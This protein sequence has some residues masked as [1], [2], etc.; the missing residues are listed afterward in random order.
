MEASWQTKVQEARAEVDGRMEPKLRGI[1]RRIERSHGRVQKGACVPDDERRYT[2]DEVAQVLSRAVQPVASSALPARRP[3][4]GITLDELEAVAAEAGIDPARV[5][6][7]ALSLGERSESSGR[8]LFFGP[9]PSHV[10]D[11]VIE[12]EVPHERLSD[13]VGIIRRLL[14]VKGKVVEV[15]D[16]LEWTSDG[17]TIHIT[18]KPEGGKTKIQFMGDAGFKLVGLFGPA[19]L[20]TLI[21]LVSL[22]NGGTLTVGLAAAIVG[23]AY[24]V[25]RGLWEIVGRRAGAQYRRMVDQLSLEMAR[26]SEPR[27][28]AESG[29]A[30]SLP[31]SASRHIS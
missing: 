30:Q 31:A 13:L 11:R 16:W 29:S 22:G 26:L 28:I 21:A 15:G 19:A 24:A 17:T 27:E 3:S 20:A 2:D 5:R 4:E 14:R 9:H 1:L 8:L 12:G 18:V 7:A 25:A 23:G 10:F 6:A